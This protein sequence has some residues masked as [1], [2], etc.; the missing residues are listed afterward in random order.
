MKLVPTINYLMS[1][2]YQGKEACINRLAPTGDLNKNNP[3][4]HRP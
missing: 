4:V 3:R 2:E 1:D